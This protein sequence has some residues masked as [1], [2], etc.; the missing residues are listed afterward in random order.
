MGLFSKRKKKEKRKLPAQENLVDKEMSF[1]DHL[2]E[3]R[4]HIVRAL[5]SIMIVG[6]VVFIFRKFVFDTII[7][8]PRNE[9]FFTY[10]FFC[11]I[12]EKI[13]L[14]PVAFEL[15]AIQMGEQFFTAIKVSFFLG[16]IVSFPLVFW[17]IWKFIKPGLYKREQKA[18]RGIVFSCSTLFMMGV[19][20]G[21]FIIAPFAINFLIGFDIGEASAS[22]SLSSYVNYMT[23]FTLPTGILFQLP[24]FVY[25]LSLIGLLTPDIMRKYRKHAFIVI[26]IIAAVATPPDVITQFLVGVPVYI[27]YELS[28][29]VS[30]R[31]SKKYNESLE[32]DE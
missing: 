8:G 27:L 14:K 3:L 12:S 2:E 31:A 13:C 9:D 1:V 29:T 30:T 25:F 11:G 15:I 10:R 24:I 6:I 7:F 16:L 22:P 19:T 17:E 26:L 28:I 5:S 20:F 32:V 4:W 18:A 23:L 21:Y